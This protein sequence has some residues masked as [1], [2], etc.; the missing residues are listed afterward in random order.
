MYPS[1]PVISRNAMSAREYV[2]SSLLYTVIPQEQWT[3]RELTYHS[4]SVC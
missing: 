3:I 1:A 2:D 4:T